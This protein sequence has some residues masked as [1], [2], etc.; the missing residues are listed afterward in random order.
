MITDAEIRELR[1]RNPYD[2]DKDFKR[3]K[4]IWKEACEELE[5]MQNER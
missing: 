1:K 5:K 2:N 3:W 4:E